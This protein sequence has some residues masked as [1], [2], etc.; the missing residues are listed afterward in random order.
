MLLIGSAA[1][2]IVL[3]VKLAEV[4]RKLSLLE[5]EKNSF[6]QQLQIQTASYHL[7][8]NEIAFIAQPATKKIVLSGVPKF[9]DALAMV[10]YNSSS[11]EVFLKVRNLPTPPSD[12]QYQLWAIVAGKPVDAGVF[13]VTADL[14]K[15]KTTDNPQ[16]F[17]VTL[18]KKGGSPTP[19]MEA[20]YVIGNI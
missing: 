13:D 2:N 17:A 10:Y 18:E 12:K 7:A 19:S 15:M 9:P 6:A 16:A 3:Y 1:F 11:K 8:Q 4:H 14:S 20:M 5:S